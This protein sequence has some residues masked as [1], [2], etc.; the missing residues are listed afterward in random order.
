[1]GLS[2][3]HRANPLASL[4]AETIFATP[5]LFSGIASLILS[6]SETDTIAQHVKE[7]TEKLLKLFPKTPEPVV[8][9]L[10]G[11]LPG[12]ALLHLRQLALFM[13]IC[14]LPGN[15]LH[16]IAVQLLTT[17]KQSERNW[18]SEII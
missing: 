11:R 2:R 7:T 15:I 10:A 3:R 18:F 6:K 1:M 4:R 8:F 14:H 9:F 5:V 12:E 13:L 16:R 17:A